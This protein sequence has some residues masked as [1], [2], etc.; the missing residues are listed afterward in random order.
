MKI[1]LNE[2]WRVIESTFTPP[3][4]LLQRLANKQAD[5]WQ[6]ES[7]CQT[8][9]ALMTAIHEKVILAAEFYPKGGRSMKV[10]KTVMDWLWKLPT[11]IGQK[12]AGEDQGTHP[13]SQWLH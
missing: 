7:W 13:T 2:H 1:Q 10:D 3:Q 6:I 12:P 5:T 8:R 11:Q 9:L 4:W